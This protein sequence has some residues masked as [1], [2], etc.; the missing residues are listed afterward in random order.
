MASTALLSPADKKGP[1]PSWPALA[2]RP[3]Y[4]SL[5]SSHTVYR[6]NRAPRSPS[7]HPG[8]DT[9]SAPRR[10]R[11]HLPRHRQRYLLNQPQRL[12]PRLLRRGLPAGPRGEP[13]RPALLHAEFL[14]RLLRASW[15][16]GRLGRGL[17][18][19]ASLA[20]PALLSAQTTDSHTVPSPRPAGPD[21]CPLGT[22]RSVDGHSLGRGCVL[23]PETLSSPGTQ[24][25]RRPLA[26]QPHLGLHHLLPTSFL[27][28]LNS[29][30]FFKCPLCVH[31]P[32]CKPQDD[33]VMRQ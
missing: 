4:L 30:Y 6:A 8:P 5:A 24:S 26:S 31:G 29:L 1:G 25:S 27:G 16:H 20:T 17:G 10:E 15:A 21:H 7:L 22:A 18:G 13:H 12:L 3:S 33:G 28:S 32:P 14:L 9:P 11:L 23:P 19:T 2:S